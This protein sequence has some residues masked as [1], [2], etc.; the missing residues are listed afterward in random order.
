MADDEQWLKNRS[1]AVAARVFIVEIRCRY[2]VRSCTALVLSCTAA[3]RRAAAASASCSISF[4]STSGASALDSSE[5]SCSW[6]S[7]R[8]PVRNFSSSS[9]SMFIRSAASAVASGR[10]AYAMRVSSSPRAR[11]SADV[12]DSDHRASRNDGMPVARATVKDDDRSAFP[13]PPA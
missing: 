1:N 3:R 8:R 12:L 11:T 13:P 4:R 2:C 6:S 7:F 10:T 5:A 9:P